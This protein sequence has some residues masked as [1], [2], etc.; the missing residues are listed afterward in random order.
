MHGGR[1]RAESAGADRGAR[2]TVTLPMAPDSGETEPAA[3]AGEP[4]VSAGEPAAPRE[5]R[6]D[7]DAVLQGVRVLLV[8]DDRDFL[9]S[10]EVTL[11]DR[12]ARVTI[13]RS[14][15]AALEAVK[16]AVPDVVISD[17]GM[18]DEDGYT[19][20]RELRARAPAEG[21]K[22]PA[23]ALTAYAA[24]HDRDRSLAAGFQVHLAKPMDPGLLAQVIAELMARRRA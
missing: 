5:G 13:V 22:V 20:I 6:A 19:L 2:F 18:P 8:D 10:L 24:D 3:S 16:K 17:L 4:A 1:V 9:E 14:A 23:I 12:G 11:E 7:A 15:H 21:G